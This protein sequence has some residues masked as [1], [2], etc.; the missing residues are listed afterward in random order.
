ML[1]ILSLG[2]G[3]QSST[4][5]LMAAHGEITPIPDAAIFADT[6]AEPKSVYTYLDFLEGVL[7]FPIIRVMEKEGIVAKIREGEKTGRGVFVPFFTESPTG[8]GRGQLQRQCSWEYK[9]EPIIRQ[10]RSMIGLK[11]GQ[12]APKGIQVTQYI[13]IS[14][15]EATRMKPSRH[16]YMVNRWPLI[17]KKMSRADCLRWIERHGYARPG[18]SACTFCPYHDDALWRDMKLNDPASFAEA[19]EVDRIIR[20]G[21]GSK[22]NQRLFVHSSMKPLDEVDFR[23]A[24][25]AGQSRLFDDECEGICGL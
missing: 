19:V 17:E 12:R 21:A 13:G 23:N 22:K 7:P 2:A 18:K 3:V 1:T 11:P 14:T 8:R 6:G 4:M 24:E 25:D 5:A 16:H 10:I 9:I 15:D 20:N